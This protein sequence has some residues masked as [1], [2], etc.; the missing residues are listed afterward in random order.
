MN[1]WCVDA[2]EGERLK[3]VKV[4]R[5]SAD[6]EDEEEGLLVVNVARL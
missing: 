1:M 3:V 6:Q 5:Y 4:T 2:D